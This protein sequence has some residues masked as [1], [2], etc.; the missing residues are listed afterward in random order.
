[1]ALSHKEIKMKIQLINKFSKKDLYVGMK[2]G[3]LWERK[4]PNEPIVITWEDA[5]LEP[6]VWSAEN[7]FCAEVSERQLK[8]VKKNFKKNYSEWYSLKISDRKEFDNE[9]SSDISYKGSSASSLREVA[10]DLG[11]YFSMV[12]EIL[13]AV[14]EGRLDMKDKKVVANV[15]RLMKMVSKMKLIEVGEDSHGN[16]LADLSQEQE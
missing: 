14:S 4:V 6:T 16:S 12:H 2:L 5:S 9:N 15:K 3:L 11:G 1:M 10:L 13:K 8:A 7:N